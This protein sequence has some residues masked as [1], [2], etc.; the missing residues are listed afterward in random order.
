MTLFLTLLSLPTPQD[1]QHG[2]VLPKDNISRRSRLSRNRSFSADMSSTTT[3]SSPGLS[4]HS[5]STA[6][7]FQLQHLSMLSPQVSPFNDHTASPLPSTAQQSR[8][9]CHNTTTT[10]ATQDSQ[11]STGV[12]AQAADD[13]IGLPG[14]PS[15]LLARSHTNGRLRGESQ[16]LQKTQSEN[17][18]KSAGG[19][20]RASTPPLYDLGVDGIPKPRSYQ[21]QLAKS[22]AA[23]LGDKGRTSRMSPT[24]PLPTTHSEGLH[25]QHSGRG[26]H[27]TSSA[28]YSQPQPSHFPVMSSPRYSASP[29]GSSSPPGIRC[30]ALVR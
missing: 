26:I 28:N 24:L 11:H 17:R 13:G 3:F 18:Q 21:L 23:G 12:P 7:G 10:S 8:I 16:A 15:T 6:P 20:D 9:G 19:V 5:T 2:R 1:T 22:A 25:L 27:P 4:P 14:P 29:H 30:V